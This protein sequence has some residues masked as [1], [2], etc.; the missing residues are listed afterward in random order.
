MSIKSFSARLKQLQREH[1]TLLRRKNQPQKH[2]NGIFDRCEN[3]VLTAA[4]TPLEWRYDLNPKN[5]PHLMTR[6]G[7]NCVYNVGAIEHN[8]NV[9]LIRSV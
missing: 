9:I 6:L 2:G 8:G 7:V 1:Q 5:N 3:P 4:H